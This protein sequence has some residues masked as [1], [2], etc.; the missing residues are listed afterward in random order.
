MMRKWFTIGGV[1]AAILLAGLAYNAVPIQAQ[2]STPLITAANV[3][4]V[5]PLLS[6]L[7][8]DPWDQ[9]A[10][11]VIYSHDG[12]LMAVGAS[13]PAP[14]SQVF[15]THTGDKGAGKLAPTSMS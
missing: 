6:S 1:A 8:P 10:N 11:K 4:Q 13:F 9:S 7:I 5:R 3:A 2:S 12:S 14:L 15:D